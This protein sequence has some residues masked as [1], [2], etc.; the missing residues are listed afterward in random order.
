MIKRRI[1]ELLKKSLTRN[2]SVA[3]MG[4]RLLVFSQ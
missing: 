3:L 1:E 2:A 4:P